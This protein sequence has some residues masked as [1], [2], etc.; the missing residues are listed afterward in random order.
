MTAGGTTT[1]TRY[2]YDGNQIVL[3]FQKTG[4]GDLAATDLSHRYLWGPAV[5]QL[6]ADEQVHYDGLQPEFGNVVWTLTDNENTVRDLATYSN[7]TTTVENHR[8][9]SA[10]GQLLSQT[11]PQTGQA[12]AVDCVFAYTGRALDEAT[13]LQNNDERWY[14]AITGRWLSQDPIGL[15]GGINLY[16]YCGNGPVDRTDASGLDFSMYC[17]AAY[18]R[19]SDW[20]SAWVP[21]AKVLAAR[22]KKSPKCAHC[23]GDAEKI[24]E[25][26]LNEATHTAAHFGTEHCD[27]WAN[28]LMDSLRAMQTGGWY[29]AQKVTWTY[30]FYRYFPE[31]WRLRHSAVKITLCDGSVF[32]ADDG[33]WSGIGNT[34]FLPED[35]PSNGLRGVLGRGSVPMPVPDLSLRLV[36]A[37]ASIN[38]AS[39]RGL[40]VIAGAGGGSIAGAAH[41]DCADGPALVHFSGDARFHSNWWRHP[42]FGG[43]CRSRRFLGY[44][45][46]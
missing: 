35:I 26:L 12:A 29:T 4:T 41:G 7:G 32:Y 3:Q 33:W 23:S 2:V 20:P 19:P 5:D 42:T 18:P 9:F 27:R 13:G 40:L 30:R 6:L 36:E 45:L 37:M 22:L 39:G 14:E 34:F 16:G 1:Q 25:D 8:E 28:N 15:N 10:Y 46:E 11:N 21:N 43:V 17:P 24:L 44:C 38:E 31:W